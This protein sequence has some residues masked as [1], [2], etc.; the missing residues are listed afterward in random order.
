MLQGKFITFEGID[1]SGKSTQLRMVS[2]ELRGRGL[3]VIT[4]REPGGTPLGR[5]LREA[6]LETEETVSPLAELLLF[7]AD[8]AQHVELLI[9]PSLAEGR[10]VI[11]DRYADATFA[12]QGAGR[13]FP[14]T[15][16]KQIIEL[17]TG[18]LKPD[19]TLFFDISVEKA[20]KRMISHDESDNRKKNRM[21]AETGD[22]YSSVRDAYLRIAEKEPQ[23]FAVIDANG[24]VDEIQSKVAAIVTEFLNPQNPHRTKIG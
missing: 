7:A 11:S 2:G 17:A 1:G 9:K 10:I 12:Y 13:G 19:L 23:R 6:F 15:T 5:R 16:V 3:D 4:T 8:R 18:G 24:S 22:F 20:L 21:D 14:E